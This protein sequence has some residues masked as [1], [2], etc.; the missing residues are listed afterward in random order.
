MWCRSC[1]QDVPGIASE[2]GAV[3]CARCQTVLSPPHKSSPKPPSG[4]AA[5]LRQNAS[6]I[7]GASTQGSP[8]DVPLAADTIPLPTLDDWEFDEQLRAAARLAKR[9]QSNRTQ[10]QTTESPPAPHFRLDVPQFTQNHPSEKDR[11][12]VLGEKSGRR[13]S[14]SFLAWTVLSLGLMTFVGGAVLLGWSFVGQRPDLWPYG[15]PL[16]LF[17]QAGLVMGVVLQLDSLWQSNHHTTQ[18]LGELD[19]RL[20]ELRRATSL[21]GSSQ[22]SAGQSFYSHFADGAPP[23]MLLA[24]LKGQIDLLASRLGR[25]SR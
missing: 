5:T 19:S 13:Q 11:P 24:D 16:T 9:H 8:L 18:T 3:C 6:S 1:Q 17:G 12:E 20:V 21:L 14:P 10:G 23:D 22:T 25:S 15:L 2:Q 7:A 4:R